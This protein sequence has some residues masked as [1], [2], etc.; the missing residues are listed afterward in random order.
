MNVLQKALVLHAVFCAAAPSPCQSPAAVRPPDWTPLRGTTEPP[1][2]VL[3]LKPLPPPLQPL[4][5]P[6]SGGCCASVMVTA[7]EAPPRKD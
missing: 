1:S 2:P 4:G 3:S 5:N 7:A 6:Q